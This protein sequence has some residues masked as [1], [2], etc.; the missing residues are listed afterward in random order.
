MSRLPPIFDSN[1]CAIQERIDA[2]KKKRKH[3]NKTT[4]HLRNGERAKREETTIRKGTFELV[5]YARQDDTPVGR[6]ER[7]LGLL[8]TVK[9][10]LYRRR[11]NVI[12]YE[13]LLPVVR[14]VNYGRRIR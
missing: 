13:T 12:K 7:L 14:D 10:N 2:F 4:F 8:K 9:S 5:V 1:L 6:T 11:T 3:T